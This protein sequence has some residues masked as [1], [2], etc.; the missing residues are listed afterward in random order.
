MRMHHPG[1]TA[2][3]GLPRRTADR[4]ATPAPRLAAAARSSAAENAPGQP[5]A[6][7][8]VQEMKGRLDVDF[9]MV[10]V[11]TDM[12]ALDVQAGD[13]VPPAAM[14]ALQRSASSAVVAQALAERPGDGVRDV[15]RTGGRLLDGPVRQEMEGRFGEGFSSVRLHTGSAARRSA[16]SLGARAYTSG[17]HVVIGEGVTDRQTLAHEL[18]HVVQQRH[19][20]VAGTDDGTGLKVSDPSDRFER[21]ADATA[22]LAMS[23][24]SQLGVRRPGRRQ[25]G[26]ARPQQPSVQRAPG[27]GE[28]GVDTE[29]EESGVGTDM[30]ELGSEV[31]PGDLGYATPSSSRTNRRASSS[32]TKTRDVLGVK[33]TR[34]KK[35]QLSAEDKARIKK[36][37][38]ERKEERVAFAGKVLAGL[39]KKGWEK[40]GGNATTMQGFLLFHK[41]PQVV[42]P[43]SFEDQRPRQ[44]LRWISSVTLRHLE[45]LKEEKVLT[46]DP[47]EVQAAIHEGKLHIACNTNEGNKFLEDNFSNVTGKPFLEQLI[48]DNP[49][50]EALL[51]KYTGRSHRHT[52]KAQGRLFE[53]SEGQEG[54]PDDARNY[55]AEYAAVCKAL[56]SPIV[57][58]NVGEE[59]EHAESRIAQKVNPET[60][61]M[62][63]N[64]VVAGTKRPCVSCLIKLFAGQEKRPGPFWFA[65]PANIGVGEYQEMNPGALV[66]RVDNEVKNTYLTLKWQCEEKCAPAKAKKQKS[67]YVYGSDSDTDT[68]GKVANYGVRPV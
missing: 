49:A 34:K 22:R 37:K 10:P 52:V 45:R 3:T 66:D 59:G 30:A 18:T 41:D 43:Y 54:H 55:A 42:A 29:M 26:P 23:G 17:E 1:K 44:A 27:A 51:G 35:K 7:P 11:H 32:R 13:P 40:K 4:T 14:L 5:L 61:T 56:Q 6:A 25:S 46:K 60:R 8:L 31:D 65:A 50:D 63:A 62:P 12:A 2:D 15:L 9:C 28:P 20:P 53:S 67:T 47:V 48:K 36:E 38:K 64:V 39:V 57:V 24:T 16:A 58:A 19:G 33:K 21:D 68:E